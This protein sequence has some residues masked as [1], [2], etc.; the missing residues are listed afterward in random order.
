MRLLAQDALFPDWN[1]TENVGNAWDAFVDASEVVFDALSTFL[2]DT[3]VSSVEWI[4]TT[5]PPIVVI[6]ALALVAWF[7]KGWKL[8]LGTFVAFWAMQSIGYFEPTMESLAI[9]LVAALIALVIGVPLGILASRSGPASK[10]LR[11]VLDFMQTMP[12]FVYL[13]LAVALVGVGAAGGV[14]ASVIFAMPPAVRLTELGIR[15]V[16]K[17]VVEAAEAFGATPGEVLRQVQL[18][19]ALPT[20]MA[21]VNQVIMLSLSMVVIGGL[22]GGG[23]IAGNVVEGVTRLDFGLGIVAGLCVVVLAVFLDRVTSA[24]GGDDGAA[25]AA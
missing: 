7:S 13:M 10:I 23:G 16:D 2:D 11:P 3:L 18:P 20:I 24:L 12:S 22:A 19:L 21:G 5:P 17:E 6:I 8:G 25:A 1:I 15:Q 4:L 14:L 9:V